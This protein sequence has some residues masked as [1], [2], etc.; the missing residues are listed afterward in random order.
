MGI[1]RQVATIAVADFI[2]RAAYQMGKTPML[3]LFALSLGASDAYLGLIVSV[4]TLTGMMA[5][6]WIGFLSDCSGRR[7]WLVIGTLFFVL[8]PFVYRFVETPAQLFMVRMVHGMATAIFGPVTLAFV[9]EQTVNERAE[10]LGWFS[11]ARTAGYIAGP[12]ASG[13]MMV[14]Y[15]PIQIFTFIGFFSC[16]AFLPVLLTTDTGTLSNKYTPAFRRKVWDVFAGCG[17]KPGV[18]LAGGLEAAMYIALYSLK[19]FFPVYYLSTGHSVA[20]TGTFFALQEATHMVLKPL[21]GR[22]GDRLGHILL[23]TSG[24]AV[25]SLTMLA[26]AFVEDSIT[27]LFL[28]VLI[29]LSQ[30]LIIPS[31]VALASFQINGEHMGAAM[32]M[33]GML[34][35]AG[36]VAGPILAGVL[37]GW[38][39]FE[40]TVCVIGGMIL[41]VTILTWIAWIPVN[42]RLLLQSRGILK[43][44][45][46]P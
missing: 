16:L 15:T 19:A 33:I 9:A 41:T 12:A 31:V 23:I 44:F 21:G 17:S 11:M 2:V 43:L 29:G 18:W 42:S 20:L 1:Q 30:A 32:G 34:K 37:M 10:Q 5:K 36:K 39:N 14:Y 27:L 3:P 26:I 6:P 24:M 35:N 4:S 38:L 25:L 28:S 13:W 40:L 8:M 7:N 46:S 22:L 45:K